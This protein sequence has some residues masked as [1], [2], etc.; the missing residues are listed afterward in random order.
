MYRGKAF[1]EAS[2][3]F[4]LKADKQDEELCHRLNSLKDVR[5]N[6]VKVTDVRIIKTYFDEAH[7][8]QV[9]S[10]SVMAEVL[11]KYDSNITHLNDYRVNACRELRKHLPKSGA[12][13]AHSIDTYSP[14]RL[15]GFISR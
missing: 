12:I 8:E 2:I 5:S 6:T 7:N 1:C 10:I 9:T 3:Y 14:F 4:Y 13:M 15:D 11:V